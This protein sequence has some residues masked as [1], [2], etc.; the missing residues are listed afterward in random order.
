MK[1]NS[2]IIKQGLGFLMLAACIFTSVAQEEDLPY[3]SGSDGSDGAFAPPRSLP[4]R[5][6]MAFAYDAA[7]AQIVIFGGNDRGEP[8]IRPSGV[9]PETWVY[10]GRE[11]NRA[12][13]QTFVSAREGSEMAYDPVRQQVMMFGGQRADGVYLND[14]WIW[15]GTNW[16]QRNPAN[17]PSPRSEHEMVWDPVNNRVLLFGGRI[18]N[19]EYRDLW[20]WDG[21][22]W[23]EIQAQNP[24]QIGSSYN[25]STGDDL[26]WEAITGRAILYNGPHR[27]MWALSG[28]TW[29]E[30]TSG[31]QPNVGHGFRMVWDPVRQEILLF[32]GTTGPST[33]VYKNGEWAE[34]T[35]PRRNQTRSYYG[36]VWH[37]GLERVVLFG[38]DN[39]DRF[40]QQT[41]YWNG[42]NWEA[43]V[44]RWHTFDM[45]GRNNG[46]WQ[47]TTIDI[48]ETVEVVFKK[49]VGNTP[50]VW[51]ASGQVRILGRIHLNGENAPAT[52][53]SGQV[54]EGGPGGFAGG[55]GGIRFD[56]SGKHAGTPGQGPGGGAAPAGAAANGEPGQYNGVYGNS[57]IQPLVGGSGG[58]GGSASGNNNGGNGGGGGGA[59][60]IASSRDIVID[61]GIFANGGNRI[62]GGASYGGSGSGG[63]VRL[64]ADRILGGGQVEAKGQLNN[65]GR[66]RLEAYYRPFAPRTTPMPSA[67]APVQSIQLAN[68]PSLN[69]VSVAGRPV[70]QPPTGSFSSPD[71]IFEEAG[72]VTI[73][74]QG[75]NIPAGTQVRL[76]ITTTE[77][78]LL[79]PAQGAPPVSL[80]GSG[81]AQFTAR[82]PRG[83]GTVQAFAEF[84]L[85][86]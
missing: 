79:F 57:M 73:Q 69:V 41:D 52:D 5:Y 14:T 10:N 60:L 34:K 2:A 70:A 38:G 1:T 30:I 25:W 3:E 23:T 56:V 7:R 44:S 35:P 8:P 85:T 4:N 26:V 15:N 68:L 82:V 58:G 83:Q 31:T 9:K 45:S 18:A 74:V 62:W 86:P 72:D 27:K 19:A 77:G 65:H 28:T 81:T 64:V 84:S 71:V 21:T 43:R 16:T 61:G 59:I 80:N 78:I 36:L 48:P 66:V 75:T 40:F 67:T 32:S 29:T 50:V 6:G 33:W 49:N 37:A 51:L 11:W 54:A 22:N 47:F 53:F 12:E 17:S 20:S 24:P 39:G 76:R 63:A 55:L 42:A 13:T 46:V